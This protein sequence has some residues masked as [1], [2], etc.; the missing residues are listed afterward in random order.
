MTSIVKKLR[1]LL[2]LCFEN[3]RIPLDQSCCERAA[4]PEWCPPRLRAHSDRGRRDRTRQAST[5][6]CSESPGGRHWTLVLE[7]FSLLNYLYWYFSNKNAR[8]LTS[9]FLNFEINFDLFPIKNNLLF[10]FW[11][12]NVL[13]FRL[14]KLFKSGDWMFDFSLILSLP[15]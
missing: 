1:Y 7:L 14:K 8:K 4:M 9:R 2:D 6:P 3:A 10:A 13:V 15:M 12:M 11:F 5:F